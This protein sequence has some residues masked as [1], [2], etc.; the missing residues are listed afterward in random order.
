MKPSYMWYW[1]ICM[2]LW[3]N[4]KG[5]RVGTGN[6]TQDGLNKKYCGWTREGIKMYNDLSTVFAYGV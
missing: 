3:K 4:T 2:I 5:A 6:L 1:S